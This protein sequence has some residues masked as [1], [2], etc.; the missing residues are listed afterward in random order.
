M[1]KLE[2]ID[3]KNG[4]RINE[5][6]KFYLT[7]WIHNKNSPYYLIINQTPKLE[8]A[9]SVEEANKRYLEHMKY[10]KKWGMKV[11][12][13]INPNKTIKLEDMFPNFVFNMFEQNNGIYSFYPKSEFKIFTNESAPTGVTIAKSYEE[14]NKQLGIEGLKIS[15]HTSYLDSIVGIKI[16]YKWIIEQKES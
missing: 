14:A 8:L 4:V 1:I 15:N 11:H 12:Y 3:I 2:E 10:L 6:L 5:S 16:K 7:W 9:T 13:T